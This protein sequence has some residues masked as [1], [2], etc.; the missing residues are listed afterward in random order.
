MKIIII[1][2]LLIGNV[3]AQSVKNDIAIYAL[4]F[5]SGA[6]NGVEETIKYHYNL[7]FARVH[8]NASRQYWDPR[9]SWQNK[10]KNTFT[11]VFP[12][13]T[14]GYHLTRGISRISMIGA[15]AISSN[16]F[17]GKN[18]GWKIAKKFLI[19]MACNRLGQYITYDVIYKEKL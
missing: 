15:I 13:F 10:N 7:G 6:S 18:K 1:I 17:N 9:V 2:S 19:S 14:D 12:M 8:T 4:S 11:K 5:I 16:D 3:N